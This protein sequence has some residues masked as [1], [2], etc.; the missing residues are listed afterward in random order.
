MSKI[1]I[2]SHTSRSYSPLGTA[3]AGSQNCTWQLVTIKFVSQQPIIKRQSLSLNLA[4]MSGESCCLA[5]RPHSA[6]SWAWWTAAWRCWNEHSSWYT[7]MIL[8]FTAVPWRDMSYMTVKRLQYSQSMA[9]KPNVRNVPGLVRKLIFASL[10]LTRTASMPRKIWYM[11]SRIGLN[12]NIVR[13]SVASWVSPASTVN[14]A[15]TT[16]TL[17]CRCTPLV[18]LRKAKGTLAGDVD[19]GGRSSTLDSPVRGVL[20]Q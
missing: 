17:Q 18:T 13:M 7:L 14:S 9:S 16:L 2:L 12:L 4:C 20:I 3:L 6:S 19:S 5:W 1:I 10:T 15:N 8:Y 11:W